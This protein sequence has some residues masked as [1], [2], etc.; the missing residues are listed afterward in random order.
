MNVLSQALGRPPAVRYAGRIAALDVARGIAVL[1]MFIAHLGPDSDDAVVSWLWQIPDGRS[2]I[3]FATLA[4]VS[5]AILSGRNVP[6]EG[7]EL[8]RARVRIVT[9]A[10]DLLIIAALVGLVNNFIGIILAHYAVWFVLAVPMLRWRT[11]SLTILTGICWIGGPVL[12]HYGQWMLEN[13]GMLPSGPERFLLEV[14]LTGMYPGVIYL[15]FVT[16]G[17]ILGRRNI[18]DPAIALRALGLG[19]LLALIGYGGAYL[20][21]DNLE[22]DYAPSVSAIDT[23]VGEDVIITDGEKGSWDAEGKAWDGE[24][25]PW[26]DDSDIWFDE[27]DGGY[28]NN[29]EGPEWLG[30]QPPT[31]TVLISGEPHSSSIT[32]NVGS[33]GFALALIGFLLLLG[34]AVGRVLYPI[35]AVG[36]MPLTAYCL[37]LLVIWLVPGTIFSDSAW[38]VI[39]VSGGI[40]VACTLW[41]ALAGRGPLERFMHTTSVRAADSIAGPDGPTPNPNVP[42]LDTASSVT[43]DP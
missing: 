22:A 12:V 9:R 7:R 30:L 15:G 32:E 37:H 10:I 40:I 16:A 31:P 28:W 24:E 23:L 1:G 17:M 2:S 19:V 13:L 21:P 26:D 3:L 5:L 36:S 33:G 38:P 6:Y 4:G 20:A 41:R 8:A 29:G 18:T 11:S 43:V 27:E 39:L 34:P 42:P 14:L 25:K 35:A